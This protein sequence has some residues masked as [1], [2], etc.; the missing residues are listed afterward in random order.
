MK[1]IGKAAWTILAIALVVRLVIGA[2]LH[3]RLPAGTDELAYLAMANSVAAGEGF[4]D[5]PLSTEESASAITSPGFA[6]A[7]GGIVAALGDSDTVMRV[8]GAVSGTIVVALIGLI[9]WQVFRRRAVALTALAIAAVYPSLVTMSAT[10]MTEWLFLPLMLGAVAAALRTRET[11]TLGWAAL[12]GALA[13]A[14]ALTKTVGVVVAIVLFVAIWPRPRL[15]AASLAAPAV[16]GLVA[17]VCVTPWLIRNAIEFDAFV[18]ISNES[19][20]VLAGAYNEFSEADADHEWLPPAQL[21][22]LREV[23]VDPELNEAEVAR[24]L[25][26]R[27][28]EFATENPGYP[29]ALAFHNAARFLQLRPGGPTVIDAQLLGF[30]NGAEA[31]GAFK[32]TYWAAAVGFFALLALAVFGA[33]RGWLRAV[34]VFLVVLAVLAVAPLVFLAAGPRFRLPADVVLIVLAAPA[35]ASLAYWMFCSMKS[36]RLS[37]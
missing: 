32:A 7:L 29:F 4:P 3:D 28:V 8:T 25:S 37:T 31:M 14:A 9:A 11:P 17:L 12:T 26:S 22:G 15:R 27:A 16:A 33:V 2:Q 5:R 1:G 21:P 36:R 30:G 18:A 6:Y 35:A 24:E 20:F 19:G 34:P 10:T 13:G 23:I